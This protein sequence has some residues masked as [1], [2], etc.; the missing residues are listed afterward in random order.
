MKLII[1]VAVNWF[2]AEVIFGSAYWFVAK[3]HFKA[4]A[5]QN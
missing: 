1:F 5:N 4:V 2:T 3:T